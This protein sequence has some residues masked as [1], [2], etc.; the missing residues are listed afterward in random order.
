MVAVAM[1]AIG[2]AVIAL[3]KLS[4]GERCFLAV[5]TLA[6]LTLQWTQWGLASIPAGES[7]RAR[8]ALLGIVSSFLAMAMFVLLFI[9]GLVFPQGAALLSV[10]MLIQVVYLTTWD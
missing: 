4:G 7:L 9:L 3:P 10:M 1:T 5:V 8:R 6:F 2:L